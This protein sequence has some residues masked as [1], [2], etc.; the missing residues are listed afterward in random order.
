MY[1]ATTLFTVYS[2]GIYFNYLKKFIL[3]HLIAF[4]NYNI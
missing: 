1:Q 4:N 2:P 3:L